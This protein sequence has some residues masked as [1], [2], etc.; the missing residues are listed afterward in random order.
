MASIELSKDEAVDI[1]TSG[2][3][4]FRLWEGDEGG[5]YIESIEGIDQILH[6]A[7][8]DDGESDI[9]AVGAWVTVRHSPNP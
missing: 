3:E 1:N 5:L 8:S 7:V 9:H 2:G 6:V 4:K